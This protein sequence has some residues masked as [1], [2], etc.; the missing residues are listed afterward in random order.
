MTS[1]RKRKEASRKLRLSRLLEPLEA[2]E[3]VEPAEGPENRSRWRRFL[4]LFST[5]PLR[6]LL[7]RL[8]T[9]GGSPPR[10]ALSVGIGAFVGCLPIYGIHF[11]LCY[12]AARALRLNRLLT[13]AASHV[14]FPATLPFLLLAEVQ[15]G[16]RLRGAPAASME[17]LHWSNIDLKTTGLDLALGGP[18]VALVVGGILGLLTFWAARSRRA[19]PEETLLVEEAARKYL[20]TGLLHW[21]FVRGKLRY[22]P[23][24]FHLLRD[25][26]LPSG[27]TLVD[28]GCGRC[29]LFALLEAAADQTARGQYPHGWAPVPRLELHGIEAR[30]KTAAAARHAVGDRATIETADLVSAELP[31]GDAILLLDVLHY[32]RE[33]DQERLLD[34]ATAALR[35]GGL[36][37]IR[38]ADA[39]AGW[40]FAAT[41]TQERLSSWLRGHFRQ[42]FRYRSIAEWKNLCRERGLAAESHPLSQGTPYGNVL[43]IGRK[44]PG[45]L[46]GA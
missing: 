8:R 31:P 18:V 41:R 15:V 13:Y 24:Y 5:R 16:R 35:P 4:A 22:D 21:E 46:P 27:G 6:E 3:P 9:E 39:A 26:I 7:Y 2:L 43:V 40:R 33:E 42:R 38:E 25:G 45:E 23:L 34:R 20:D 29:I 36:L 11:L 30:A 44:A 37:L 14:S 12:V 19:H 1:R 17:S 32:L 10:L 28:L